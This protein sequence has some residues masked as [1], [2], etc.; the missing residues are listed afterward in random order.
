MTTRLVEVSLQDFTE[1]I[2]AAIKDGRSASFM[3][4]NDGEA[5]FVGTSEFYPSSQIVQI[6][7]RQ[8]GDNG[9]TDLDIESL[10]A[11][12]SHAVRGATV[13]GL[14]P[15]DWPQ[16]FSFARN[17]VTRLIQDQPLRT[18][19]VD[20][21]QHLFAS[22]FFQRLFAL[23]HPVSLVTCRDVSAFLTETYNANISRVYLV[24]EQADGSVSGQIKPHYPIYCDWLTRV[25]ETSSSNRLFLVGAGI[26]G[27]IYC[28]AIQRAGGIAVDVGSI[29]DLWAG[30]FSRP[31]MDPE[32]I[33][34][35]YFQKLS[36]L[37][38][39]PLVIRACAELHTVDRD[40]EAGLRVLA[41]GQQKFPHMA[42]FYL[43]YIRVSLQ[44]GQHA[45]A[46][47]LAG[48]IRDGLTAPE[49]LLL[50]RMFKVH[51]LADESVDQFSAAFERDPFFTPVLT[52]LCGDMVGKRRKSAVDDAILSAAEAAIVT[53]THALLFQLARVHGARGDFT[54]AVK[55]CGKAIEQF[56]LDDHYFSHQ[57]GWLREL[58]RQAEADRF[59]AQ[60]DRFLP[61]P[62]VK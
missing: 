25:L 46:S 4:F 9:L 31:Y 59:A 33:R 39:T 32:G 3:R 30:R 10:K 15:S 23:G 45:P 13:V 12:A 47:E 28:D 24:P 8:F 29:F 18:T 42:E 16:E 58:G 60:R 6:I 35:Y 51:Q 43:R 22:Q 56:S 7:R 52:E 17:V 40:F 49:L 41:L 38:L 34:R 61:E 21:H 54:N 11:K 62:A 14:P 57:V 50:G 26:C 36:R 55:F 2:F 44:S 27:K 48:K 37:D 20:F 53:G 5:K 1:E 19:H